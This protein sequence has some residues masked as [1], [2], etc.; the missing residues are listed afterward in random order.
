[1]LINSLY[2]NKDIKALWTMHRWGYTDK[3]IS[4]SLPIKADPYKHAWVSSHFKTFKKYLLNGVAF[5]NF[6][7][8]NG[9][10]VRRAGDQAIFLPALYNA[11]GNWL[12]VPRVMYH[13]TIDEKDGAIYHTED[14]HFQKAEA[15]FI[16]ARGYVTSGIPWEKKFK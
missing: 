7:N 13:Y 15:E 14:A 6:L 2:K 9:E 12:F 16:R 5:E 10:L 11:K 1:M 3:N 8:M 4:G